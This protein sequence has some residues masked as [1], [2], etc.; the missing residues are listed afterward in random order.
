MPATAIGPRP[1]LVPAGVGALLDE[2]GRDVRDEV[3][4]VGGVGRVLPGRLFDAAVAASADA[5]LDAYDEIDDPEPEAVLRSNAS[6]GSPGR[7]AS[8]PRSTRRRG[9]TAPWSPNCCAR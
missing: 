7:A 4:L 9:S 5:E 6:T 3:W 1:A 8:S 2:L